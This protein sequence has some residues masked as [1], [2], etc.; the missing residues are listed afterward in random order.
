MA[1]GWREKTD[2]R[3]ALLTELYASVLYPERMGSALAGINRHLDCDGVHLVGWDERTGQPLVSV[4]TDNHIAT[5]ET[6]YL[7]HYAAID[8][9]REM[10]RHTPHGQASACHDFFDD[11][12]VA[13]DEFYQDFLI[14]LGPRYIAGGS[15]YRSEGKQV[16]LVFNHLV[17]RPRFEGRKRQAIEA[18]LP[19]L[20]HWM[21][22]VLR[23]EELRQAAAF[24]ELAVEAMGYG[25]VFF[26]RGGCLLHANRQA[27]ALLGPHLNRVNLGQSGR[28]PHG[29]NLDALIEQVART[30]RSAQVRLDPHLGKPGVTLLITPVSPDGASGAARESVGR[31][32]SAPP[33]LPGLHHRASVVMTIKSA[34][35]KSTAPQDL[36][37]RWNLTPAEAAL[38]KALLAGK[39]VADHAAEKKVKVSTVRTHVRALL[40]KSGCRSIREWLLM[41]QRLDSGSQ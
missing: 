40:E 4:V 35:Q 10:G 9:R 13:R 12:F 5:A 25:V 18:W 33:H 23:A 34:A 2:E 8:P 28:P 16:H 6:A 1:K 7:K 26:D 20:T 36:I 32:A 22:Q 29:S 19:Q 17:G 39:S 30:R 38:A 31:L 15:I 37:A 3:P 11:R 27:V 24:G 21:D 41:A 14:P